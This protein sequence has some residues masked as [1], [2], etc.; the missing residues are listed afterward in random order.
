MINDLIS[1][2]MIRINNGY[3]CKKLTVFVLYSQVCIRILGLLY[4]EGFINGYYIN[5]YG[6]IVVHLKYYRNFNIFKGFKRISKTG[7]RLYC[8]VQ[9]LKKNYYYKPFVLVSTTKGLVT[10]RYAILKNIG[11]E[12]LFELNYM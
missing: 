11:G 9:D 2:M 8:K 7:C 10:H 4:K 12:V 1:D 3:T 5:K 6:Y